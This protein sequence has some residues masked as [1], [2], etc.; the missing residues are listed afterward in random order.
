MRDIIFLFPQLP[1]RVQLFTCLE[2]NCTL[3]REGLFG[4]G[5]VLCTMSKLYSLHLRS[6]AASN[7]EKAL[8]FPRFMVELIWSVKYKRWVRFNKMD[9]RCSSNAQVDLC[10]VVFADTYPK[11]QRG[12]GIRRHWNYS[13]DFDQTVQ[14]NY[15]YLVGRGPWQSPFKSLI[16]E[17]LPSYP[18]FHLNIC[19]LNVGISTSV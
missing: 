17:V 10:S 9:F 13:F 3:G 7:K 15:S 18:P 6:T 11:G 14:Y 8:K 19:E 1:E 2:A 12:K 5:S 16:S 4:P